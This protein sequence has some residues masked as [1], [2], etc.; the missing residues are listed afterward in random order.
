VYRDSSLVIEVVHRN[1]LEALKT[2]AIPS[3]T[4]IHEEKCLEDLLYAS[5]SY[6]RSAESNYVTLHP[7]HF[8][9]YTQ[10]R[11]RRPT[12]PNTL[13]F[14]AP[15]FSFRGEGLPYHESRF[16]LP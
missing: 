9:W 16:A 1:R 2:T 4:T 12:V 14:Q 8:S 11:V 6:L 5:H 3:L 15:R 10:L 7:L 13:S